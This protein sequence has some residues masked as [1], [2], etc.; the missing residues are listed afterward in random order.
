MTVQSRLQLERPEWRPFAAGLVAGTG[1]VLFGHPLDTLK[2]RVQV[3]LTSGASAST[4]RGVYAGV[5]GPLLTLP[6]LAGLNFGIYDATR[7]RLTTWW[8]ALLSSAA[9]SSAAVKATAQHTK[10]GPHESASGLV[11]IWASGVTSGWMLCNLTC[12]MTNVKVQQQTAGVSLSLAQCARRAG[13]RGLFRGYV[14]HAVMES[15][16]R[17]WYMV[18]FV[19]SKR[20]FC[21]DTPGQQAADLWKRVVCGSFG[22]ALAWVMAYPADVIRN[23]MMG[24]WKRER[25]EG[26]RDCARKIFEE[27]GVRGFWRGFHYTLLRAIPVAAV[28]LPVY[29]MTLNALNV[30]EH[31]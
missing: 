11:C 3:R 21:I 16:G 14:P 29:D 27:E 13:V 24:D 4:L 18:G 26:T 9:T 12:P 23:R 7:Q 19:S 1:N 17:G 2:V 5:A 22:G 6:F 25:Y 31:G 8:P 15:I 28:T 10:H 30:Y 20:F